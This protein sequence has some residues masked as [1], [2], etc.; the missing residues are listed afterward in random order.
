MAIYVLSCM[1]WVWNLTK[2]VL[3]AS[4]QNIYIWL[5]SSDG[6]TV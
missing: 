6:F 1:F 3:P 4:C 2:L 5:V